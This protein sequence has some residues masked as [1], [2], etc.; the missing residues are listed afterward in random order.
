MAVGI[1]CRRLNLSS[2]IGWRRSSLRIVRS[3][4][5]LQLL[6]CYLRSLLVLSFLISTPSN[7]ASN[8]DIT[9][10]C[11]LTNYSSYTT[12]ITPPPSETECERNQF[13]KAKQEMQHLPTAPKSPTRRC[14]CLLLNHNLLGQDSHRNNGR[15]SPTD[16][17]YMGGQWSICLLQVLYL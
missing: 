5:H 8:L 2:N 1:F 3:H 14:R 11:F 6:R 16:Q 13:P 9:H 12:A 10:C 4:R 15:N 17:R 7:T